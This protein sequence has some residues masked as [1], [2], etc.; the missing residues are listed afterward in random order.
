MLRLMVRRKVGSLKQVSNPWERWQLFWSDEVPCDQEI[1]LSLVKPGQE[2]DV[3]A[4]KPVLK[5]RKLVPVHPSKLMAG[6]LPDAR[7]AEY[8][9]YFFVGRFQPGNV[10]CRARAIVSS[11]AAASLLITE[12]APM[13]AIAPIVSV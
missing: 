4:M 6:V 5:L 10:A 7:C 3:F 9:D 11:P 13:V 1:S 12:P 2:L 8:A